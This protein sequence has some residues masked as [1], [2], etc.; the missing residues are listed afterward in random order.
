MIKSSDEKQP[1]LAVVE[2]SR[3]SRLR[4]FLTDYAWFLVRNL[5]GWILILAAPA[6][7]VALPGPGG[8]PLFLIGFALVTFPGKRKLTARFLRGWR[9]NIEHRFYAIGAAFLAIVIPGIILWVVAI[10]FKEQI[11]HLVSLYAPQKSVFY[12]LPILLIA[13]TWLVTRLSLKLLNFM[14]SLT[15]LL[16]RKSR[17]WLR[18][19]GVNVLPPRR[20]KRLREN[21]EDEI[22]EID[23]KYRR[24]VL[25]FWTTARPW[26]WR[27][28]G[29][30]ITGAIFF[31]MFRKIARHWNDPIVRDRVL[32]TSPMRF[33]LASV[34]F[35]IFLFAFRAFSWRK[36]LEGF[37][38][39]LPFNAS[40]RIWSVSELA[41]YLPGS[42]WQVVGRVYLCKP[43]GVSGSICSMSQI[44]ELATF[45]MANV[46]VAVSCFLFAGT[47]KMGPAAQ[48]WLMVAMCLVPLL[49]VLL[50]PKVFYSIAN[51]IMDRLGKPQITQR[52]RGKKLLALLCWSIIGLLWQSLALWIRVAEP[53]DLPKHSWWDFPKWWLVGGAYCLAWCAGFLAVWAPGGLGVREIVFVAAMQI[54]LP[55]SGRHQ[56]DTNPAGLAALLAFLSLLLRLWTIVGELM[57]A[58][59]AAA[60][61]YRGMFNLEARSRGDDEHSRQA[62]PSSRKAQSEMPPKTP[63]RSSA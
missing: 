56:F 43:Y 49:A 17:P 33:L 12:L 47:R 63:A 32:A 28:S 31:Y 52:L 62:G 55:R 38:A 57:L 21:Q 54:A 46:L 40:I 14:L 26:I 61:D 48:P 60:F 25:W 19:W 3:R 35:A 10:N 44:L 4:A 13:V 5:I 23:P 2:G 37:G 22:L 42:F 7:G 34:M 51:R 45:L 50:H 11:R 39:R 15:P 29:V 58:G 9:L 16:R 36:I 30:L 1:G 20:R 8:L 41:R 53:L 24:R 18:K 59:I 27:A 6:I